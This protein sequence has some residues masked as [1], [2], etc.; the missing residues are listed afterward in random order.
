MSVYGLPVVRG[1]FATERGASQYTAGPLAHLLT[2]GEK[3][4]NNLT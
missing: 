1:R 2:E 4:L 3:K